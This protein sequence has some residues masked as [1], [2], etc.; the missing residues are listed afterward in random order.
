MRFIRNIE[1]KTITVSV[2][3]QIRDPTRKF[4]ARRPQRS[5]KRKLQ[6]T[7]PNAAGFKPNPL[8]SLTRYRDVISADN[9]FSGMFVQTF[10]P[11]S[12]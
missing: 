9:R 7:L 1:T 12:E 3:G 6:R 11:S 8:A 2:N 4:N 5:E 10:S